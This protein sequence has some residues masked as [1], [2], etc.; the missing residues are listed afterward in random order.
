MG[1]DIRGGFGET[2]Y[3]LAGSTRLTKALRDTAL[4]AP[5]FPGG[6]PRPRYDSG[7]VVLQADP[8]KQ[9]LA[10]QLARIPGL[11]FIPRDMETQL[12]VAENKDR[13]RLRDALRAN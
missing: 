11:P 9:S 2:G 4:S 12:E 7:D 6:N 10:Q 3:K 13:I 8:R 1:G 5:A